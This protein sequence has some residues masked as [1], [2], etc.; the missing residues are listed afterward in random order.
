MWEPATLTLEP[1]ILTYSQRGKEIFLIPLVHKCGY[2]VEK[3]GI[4]MS[5]EYLFFQFF[6]KSFLVAFIHFSLI[7]YT[8]IFDKS[9][10]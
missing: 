6:V 8:L 3:M 9:L 2:F 7:M 5:D 4:N 1:L 10:T